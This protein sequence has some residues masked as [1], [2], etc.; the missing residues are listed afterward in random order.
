MAVQKAAVI[1]SSALRLCGLVYILFLFLQKNHIEDMAF[2][3]LSNTC[4]GFATKNIP[5]IQVI[6]KY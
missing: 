4:P 3:N 5:S 6:L 1:Y 2:K